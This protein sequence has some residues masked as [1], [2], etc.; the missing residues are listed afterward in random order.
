[1]EAMEDIMEDRADDEADIPDP[2]ISE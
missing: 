1:M 2:A